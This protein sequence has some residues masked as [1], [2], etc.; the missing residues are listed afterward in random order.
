MT[1]KLRIVLA[2]LNL[3]V[4]DIAGNLEKQI[5]AAI[6]ARDE[7]KADLIVFPELSITGYPPEDLLL[8]N[9]F[10][11]AAEAALTTF[12]KTIQ[13]IHCL[14]S[15]PH[16][17]SSGLYNA[18]ALIYNGNIVG[19][20]AKQHLPNYGV[21]D[22]ARYF[23]AGNLPSVIPI[24]GIPVGLVICEDLW[25][26]GPAKQAAS[27][28]ARIIISPNASP[29]EVSKHHERLQVVSKR[30]KANNLPIVYVNSVG[31]Q[32]ELVFDG[33]S[34]VVDE[35]GQLTHSAG[36]FNEVLLPVDIHITTAQT[37]IDA[38]VITLPNDI[39]K[40]YQALVLSVRDYIQKNHFPGV[41]I[42]LSGGIDSALVL[43]IAHDAIGHERV[44]AVFMPSRYTADISR[45]DAAMLSKN[46]R[47]KSDTISIESTYQTLLETL[48]PSFVGKKPD[49]T[50]ENLQARCRAILLMA[51][52]NKSGNLVLTT[53]NR[54]E[55]AVGYCTLYGDMAGGFAP[56]K[57]VPKTLVYKLANYRNSIHP[58]IPQR[59]IDRP[60]TA[61]L[62]P[63]QKD[64]DSLPPYSVLDDILEAYLNRSMSM[65]DIIAAGFDADTVKRVI[66]L[67]KR[68]EYK[69][70]QSAIGPRINSKSFGKDWRY[71]V[72]NG[73]KE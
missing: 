49:V 45:D 33:G 58:V 66:H 55:M 30:A 63:N 38:E 41:L 31:G 27:M 4:G 52:S 21:F 12:T 71:P 23:V 25:F 22:E 56:L 42:G 68:S 5:Q 36:F 40:T 6:T 10:L 15:A 44:H 17:T 8:R 48:A 2:Q 46:L 70:Q 54:S 43:A 9:D 3:T 28:G 62:A 64:E 7:L 39:E 57:D 65:T 11:D 32:D 24:N 16:Q 72:T 47:I 14:I 59:I 51:L 60:P 61:E 18:A 69:R 19:R 29:F 37:Q 20:Y 35:T 53:G 1:K 67:I 34:M 50:E 26:E 73:F 13:G